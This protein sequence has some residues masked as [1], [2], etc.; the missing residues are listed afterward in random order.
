MNIK[1]FSAMVALKCF[2]FYKVVALTVQV[3][4]RMLIFI[5]ELCSGREKIINLG[6]PVKEKQTLVGSVWAE[7]DNKT[8]CTSKISDL[9]AV[10]TNIGSCSK[11][12]L[13]HGHMARWLMTQNLV[14]L[15]QHFFFFFFF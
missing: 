14:R 13:K 15:Q 10:H 3:K 7:V 4:L 11:S 8:M 5:S 12:S 2:S 1:F 9:Q 6:V